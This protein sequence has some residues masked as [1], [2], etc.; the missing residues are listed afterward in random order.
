MLT[1]S[2]VKNA[3][4][5]AVVLLVAGLTSGGGLPA[6]SAVATGAVTG[7]VL[8]AAGVAQDPY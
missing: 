8:A 1:F 7:F 5:A 2:A 4:S 3:A 6:P